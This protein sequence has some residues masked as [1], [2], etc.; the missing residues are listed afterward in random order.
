MT[1]S[2]D[3]IDEGVLEVCDILDTV[4]GVNPLFIDT[5]DK[6]PTLTH[7]ARAE[8]LLA[9]VRLSMTCRRRFLPTSSGLPNGPW[10]VTVSRS[11]RP[12]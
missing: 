10:W 3:L 8:A 9:A 7:L 11:T 12:S 1:Q 2:R 5:C 4:M 6:F